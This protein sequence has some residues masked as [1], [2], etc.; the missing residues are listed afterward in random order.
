[1]QIKLVTASANVLQRFTLKNEGKVDEASFDICFLTSFLPA[2]SIL[3][4]DICAS[5]F[6][7]IMMSQPSER[8]LLIYMQGPK[9]TS[10]EGF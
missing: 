6:G 3:E 9:I 5:S 4:V 1:M 2:L 8:S 10:S 7:L